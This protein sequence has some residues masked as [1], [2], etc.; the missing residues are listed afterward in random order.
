MVCFVTSETPSSFNRT[1]VELKPNLPANCEACL[2][3]FNRTI[4]ELK[5]KL[6][7]FCDAA[8]AVF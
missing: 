3:A 6:C 4:V 2:N 1:I 7:E 8:F 5:L